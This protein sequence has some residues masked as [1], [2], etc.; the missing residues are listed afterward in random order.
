V[1]IFEKPDVLNSLLLGFIMKN[2][3]LEA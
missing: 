1:T 3:D 2:S